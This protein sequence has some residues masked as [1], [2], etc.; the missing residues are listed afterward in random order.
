MF[1]FFLLFFLLMNIHDI[2]SLSTTTKH[3]Q[4][5]PRHGGNIRESKR[6]QMTCCLD[7]GIESTLIR[8]I[9]HSSKMNG[10]HSN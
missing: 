6:V 1:S 4:N 2:D 3:A 7:P 9:S 8:F 10:D 5:V